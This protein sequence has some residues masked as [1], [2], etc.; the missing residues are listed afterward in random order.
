LE[1]KIR[2][3]NTTL[4]IKELN[5]IG[6]LSKEDAIDMMEALEILNTLRLHSQ[7]EQLAKGEKLNNYISV[8]NIG[9]LERDLLKDAIKTVNK[10]KKIVS[11]HFHLSMVG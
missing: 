9:K 10:F 7:L 1:H 11:Y 2:A 4:R 8:K 6:F 3:T 5:N